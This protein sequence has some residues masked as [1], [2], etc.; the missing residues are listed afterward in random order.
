M[1]FTN[2]LKQT[3][4]NPNQEPSG[5]TNPP[6]L[7]NPTSAGDKLMYWG[8]LLAKLAELGRPSSPPPPSSTEEGLGKG[9][10]MMVGA[11][12]KL[13]QIQSAFRK[14]FL[15]ELRDTFTLFPKALRESKI[16]KPETKSKEEPHLEE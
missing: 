4:T 6:Q 7:Q 1:N 8:S 9:F 11:F 13:L 16:E 3:S 15:E 10:D 14:N 2:S 12:T 5:N